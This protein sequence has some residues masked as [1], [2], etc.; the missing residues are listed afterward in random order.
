MSRYDCVPDQ[1]F[2]AMG[3]CKKSAGVFEP[4]L[5]QLQLD[6]C[7]ITPDAWITTTLIKIQTVPVIKRESYQDGMYVLV[8]QWHPVLEF[9]LGR[10]ESLT[11]WREN[12]RLF[13]QEWRDIRGLPGKG[14]SNATGRQFGVNSKCYHCKPLQ[15]NWPKAKFYTASDSHLSKGPVQVTSKK[16]YTWKKA[17]LLTSHEKGDQKIVSFPVSEFIGGHLDLL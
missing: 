4:F 12:L 1:P 2:S 6:F 3:N 13:G 5:L 11:L 14:Q 7:Q 10:L 17:T 16:L 9:D 15:Q 8:W